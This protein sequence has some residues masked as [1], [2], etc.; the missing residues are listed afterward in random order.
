M[1]RSVTMISAEVRKST[2][3]WSR[4][5]GYRYSCTHTAVAC[6]GKCL[7]YS[8][9]SLYPQRTAEWLHKKIRINPGLRER[10]VI[11]MRY[12]PRHTRLLSGLC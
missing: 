1:A 7:L 3:L 10:M 8:L 12:G 9:Y 5:R 11:G 6:T 2:I 4:S